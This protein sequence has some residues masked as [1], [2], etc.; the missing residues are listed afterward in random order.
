VKLKAPLDRLCW[1]IKLHFATAFKFK[2][3]YEIA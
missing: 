1:Q 2:L 3:N